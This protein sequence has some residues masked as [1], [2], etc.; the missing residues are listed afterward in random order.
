MTYSHYELDSTIGTIA[1]G[2]Y[3]MRLF[4]PVDRQVKSELKGSSGLTMDY[5]DMTKGFGVGTAKDSGGLVAH[6]QRGMGTNISIQFNLSLLSERGDGHNLRSWN[7]GEEPVVPPAGFGK[8]VYVLTNAENQ[9]KLYCYD[10][11][12]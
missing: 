12:A 9:Y 5:I 3:F 7:L 4:D 2:S 6:F 11:L 1:I 8:Y 10:I